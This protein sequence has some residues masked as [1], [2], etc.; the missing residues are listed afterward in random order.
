MAEAWIDSL[1]DGDHVFAIR[2]NRA[3]PLIGLVGLRS[4]DDRIAELSYWIGK[5]H[6]GRGYATE[7]AAAI[8]DYGFERLRLHRIYATSLGRNAASRRV[9]EKVGMVAEGV[10]RHHVWHRGRTEDLHY[11]GILLDDYAGR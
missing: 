1:G 4:D 9:L 6:W 10:L 8:V 7:A 5:P 2:E 3:D 11:H